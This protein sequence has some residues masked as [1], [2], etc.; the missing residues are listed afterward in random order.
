MP[1][2]MM[3]VKM[4]PC[5]QIYR[6]YIMIDLLLLYTIRM[7]SKVTKIADQNAKYWQKVS[8]HGLQPN[9]YVIVVKCQLS[10]IK[11][12]S[13]YPAPWF[14]K[15]QVAFYDLSLI[16]KNSVSIVLYY[17]SD[18]FVHDVNVCMDVVVTLGSV[19]GY[20]T[21]QYSIMTCLG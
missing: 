15:T 1:G 17:V 20:D 3:H 7:F 12:L 18:A 14:I 19:H 8:M 9:I 11:V 4:C 10:T 5:H 13:V 2:I 16:S 6:V 21:P